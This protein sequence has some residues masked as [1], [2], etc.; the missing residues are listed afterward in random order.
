M[1][2]NPTAA[3][4]VSGL[5]VPGQEGKRAGVENV[6]GQ[7]RGRVVTRTE[8]SLISTSAEQGGEIY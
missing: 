3:M 5:D 8:A 7:E 1:S 6:E 4:P 2:R